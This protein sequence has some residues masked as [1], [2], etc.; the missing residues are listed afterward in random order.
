[1]PSTRNC[2]HH[3]GRIARGYADPSSVLGDRFSDRAQASQDYPSYQISHGSKQRSHR[4]LQ[5]CS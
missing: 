2:A 4:C 3:C 5:V 1:M